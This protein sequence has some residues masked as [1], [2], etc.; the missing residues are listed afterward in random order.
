MTHLYTLAFPED[1]LAAKFGIISQPP[2][3]TIN[4]TA[5]EDVYADFHIVAEGL[6]CNYGDDVDAELEC[7]RQVSW[8]QIEEYINRYD[9]SPSIAFTNYIR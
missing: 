6:G 9:A 3:V 1:P 7:M 5:T 4:L 2:S 8:V